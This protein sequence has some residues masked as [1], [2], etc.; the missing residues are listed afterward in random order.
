MQQLL[1]AGQSKPLDLRTADGSLV[2]TV[3]VDRH[4]E[5]V[6]ITALHHPALDRTFTNDRLDEG[7]TYLQFL[8][9]EARKG[10]QVFLIEA[11]AGALT[12]AAAVLDQAEQDM[13][14]GVN[15]NL[16]RMTAPQPSTVDVSDILANPGP[17]FADLKRNARNDYSRTRVGSQ[18]PT[19]PQLDRMRQHVGGVV[20]TAQG[21]SWTLL[22]GIVDRGLGMAHEVHGS[23]VI[24]SVKL[25]RR[26]MAYVEQGLEVAA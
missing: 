2:L 24:R 18:P 19:A 10:T 17:S 15:A 26:G 16:G 25:N 1:T 14:D 5:G 4:H 3:Q 21:Q 12:S 13:V 11:Q 9:D 6:S 23:Y 7:R 8:Y 20:T 22:K